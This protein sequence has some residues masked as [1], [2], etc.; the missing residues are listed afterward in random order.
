MTWSLGPYVAFDVETT[1]VDV[2]NDRII[3]AAVVSIHPGEIPDVDDWLIN[4]G[5]DIPEAATAVHGVTTAH[6]KEHGAEPARAVAEIAER[7]CEAFR[8]H[9]PVVAMNASFDLTLLDREL[10]R[11]GLGGLAERLGSYDAVRPVLDPYVID[12]EVDKYRRGKRTLSALCE[13]YAVSL[14]GAHDAA[15][16][17]LAACRVLYR[18]AQRYPMEVA[19]CSV[20]RL[21]DLQ[22]TWHAERQAD[23]AKYLKLQGRDASGV[24]GSWPV[25]RL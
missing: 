9:I 10:I 11:Y 8:S 25:R 21:H 16:D 14:D 18:L 7:L 13:H 5:I 19:A 2:E 20:G 6:A 22:V 3:T 12:R 15:H 1:G 4:P 23:F 24:D 17:A